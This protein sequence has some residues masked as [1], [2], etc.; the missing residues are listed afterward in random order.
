MD[1]MGAIE[2]TIYLSKLY[3]ALKNLLIKTEVFDF[4]LGALSFNR[5]ILAKAVGLTLS[6]K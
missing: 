6:H 5:P 3:D 1:T 2:K 4:D